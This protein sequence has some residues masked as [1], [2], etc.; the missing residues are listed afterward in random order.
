MFTEVLVF[1]AF[2]LY[3]ILW[4]RV[5]PSVLHRD[6]DVLDCCLHLSCSIVQS[7]SVC[8]E[9]E[10]ECE[11]RKPHRCAGAPLAPLRRLRLFGAAPPV[12]ALAAA[13]LG[14]QPDL[15]AE[16]LRERA[17]WDGFRLL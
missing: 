5:I 4:A 7:P 6:T 1:V 12:P 15:T 13:T 14:G 11:R 17:P 16:T 3:L 10:S 2:S 9:L 8:R